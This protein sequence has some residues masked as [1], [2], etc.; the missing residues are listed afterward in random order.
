MD[1]ERLCGE[2]ARG[3]HGVGLGCLGGHDLQHVMEVGTRVWDYKHTGIPTQE[4]CILQ[5]L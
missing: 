2:G 3:H 4:T 5:V 1:R